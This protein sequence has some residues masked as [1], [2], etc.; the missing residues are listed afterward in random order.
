MENFFLPK[1][2]SFFYFF[3]LTIYGFAIY[4]DNSWLILLMIP[5]AIIDKIMFNHFFFIEDE[6]EQ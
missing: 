5:I 6:D 4:F 1:I 2:S 3:T